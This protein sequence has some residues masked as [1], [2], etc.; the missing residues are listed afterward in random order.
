MTSALKDVATDEVQNKECGTKSP[1]TD[2][3]ESIKT[4]IYDT[5]R[6]ILSL[7]N[8]KDVFCLNACKDYLSSLKDVITDFPFFEKKKMD[9]D[10]ASL[11][12]ASTEMLRESHPESYNALVSCKNVIFKNDPV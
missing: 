3:S 10:T 4:K 9:S 11:Y 5:F 1:Y 7:I 2:V 8:T 12:Q 6:D